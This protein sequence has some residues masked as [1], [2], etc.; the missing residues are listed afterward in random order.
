LENSLTNKNGEVNMTERIAIKLTDKIDHL[1]DE[2]SIG[3]QK[4]PKGRVIIHSRIPGS[5]ELKLE[6][7]T[8]NLVV[9]RGRHWLMQRAFNASV[10]SRNWT[11]YFINHFAVGT[12]GAVA[13]SPL[14]PVAP[15]LT[16]YLLGSHGVIDSGT[17]DTISG[18][19]YFRFDAGYPI[20]VQ[21]TDITDYTGDG[22]T[23]TDSL[24]ITGNCDRELIAKVQVSVGSSQCNDSGNPA[25]PGLPGDPYQD[26][27]EAG[28]FVTDSATSPT[29]ARLFAR[30]SFSTIRKDLHRELVFSWFI[31][32]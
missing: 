30:V 16:N 32:F 29:V 7:D 15:E 1:Y 31:Y 23:H 24:S 19:E 8:D 13:T 17:F 27:S 14:S 20:A 9:Y 4:R 22:C 18:N 26:L 2:F 10:G 3:P 12:G 25:N 5:N 6:E 21:D 28:L 11:T